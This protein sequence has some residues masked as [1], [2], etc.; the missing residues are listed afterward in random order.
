LVI[1]LISDKAIEVVH[2]DET[3]AVYLDAGLPDPPTGRTAAPT[4]VGLSK[5]RPLLNTRNN[6]NGSID[7]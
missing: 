2:V 5:V 7:V 6:Q 1:S 4:S 3:A